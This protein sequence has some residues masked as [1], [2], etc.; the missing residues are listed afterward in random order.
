MT[1]TSGTNLAAGLDAAT[2]VL[3]GCEACTSASLADVENRIIT[4]TD[5]QPNESDITTEGLQARLEANAAKNIFST[6]VGVGL[7]FNTELVDAISRVKGSNYISV[8]TPGE[9]PLPRGLQPQS[10]LGACWPGRA[11][12]RGCFAFG[13][14]DA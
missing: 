12:R 7:D 4:I 10:T 6:F 2:A 11:I 13:G 14:R 9:L 5:A 1:D 8:H 3:T